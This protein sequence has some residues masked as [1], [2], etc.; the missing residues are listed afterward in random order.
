MLTDRNV[1]KD[2]WCL[3]REPLMGTRVTRTSCSDDRR[4]SL[5]GLATRPGGLL[6]VVVRAL[7]PPRHDGDHHEGKSAPV[8]RPGLA[9][10]DQVH[11]EHDRRHRQAETEGQDRPEA[12]LLPGKRCRPPGTH[13]DQ[14]DRQRCD[15]A[16]EPLEVQGMVQLADDLLG[17]DG[18]TAV[19]RGDG[20]HG[21]GHPPPG[22]DHERV[23]AAEG[24]QHTAHEADELGG[25]EV[26]RTNGIEDVHVGAPV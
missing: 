3:S 23:E 18:L 10:R 25:L 1:R 8:V 20:G 13:D 16:K 26:G 12:L 15:R 2:Y 22:G 4:C 6:D 24:G 7:R 5:G 21:V 9:R 19:L 17:G 14:D 11:P